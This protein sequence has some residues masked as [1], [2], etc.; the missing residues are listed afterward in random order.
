MTFN[1]LKEKSF[2]SIEYWDLHE[3]L[4]FSCDSIIFYTF[5]TCTEIEDIV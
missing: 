5:Q 4:L 3:L 1:N 2:S